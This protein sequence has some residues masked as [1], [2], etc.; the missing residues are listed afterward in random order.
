LAYAQTTTDQKTVRARISRDIQ[1]WD[2][3]IDHRT[4]TKGDEQTAAWISSELQQLGLTPD[5]DWF[6][7]E[8][9]V[10][11]ECYVAWRD[12]RADGVPLF[13]GGYTDATGLQAPL[14]DLGGKSDIGLTPFGPGPWHPGT[15]ALLQARRQDAHQAIVAVAAGD[16][17][18]PGLS[19]L[20]ADDYMKPYGPPVLQV[21]TEHRQWLE[22]ARDAAEPVRLVA[23]VTLEQTRASNVQAR[24]PGA[25]PALRPLVIMTPCSAWWTCT[26]ERAGGITLWLECARHFAASQPDRTVIFTAN[27]GHELG[28]VGLERY[29]NTAPELVKQAHAWVHLGANFAAVDSDLRFQA[30]T[31]DLMEDGLLALAARGIREP[32]ITPVEERPLGEARNI[33]DGG[34][35]YVSLLGN[36]RRFHHPDD[37][38][39]DAVDVDRTLALNQAMLE[40]VDA[41]ARG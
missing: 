14:A 26:S 12:K 1:S 18:R 24:I 40:V 17:V 3:I 39:P 30:S 15:K 10:L 4:G 38:W 25:D 11:H 21:A 36:N 19:L 13:D 37:R 31:R 27:T 34:G 6:E 2:A 16:V 5:I 29:L 32:T 7:F 22:V 9:R 28:H 41:L 23:H 20:N 35:H 33:Y 8:R